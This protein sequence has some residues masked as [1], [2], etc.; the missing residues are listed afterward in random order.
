MTKTTFIILITLFSFSALAKDGRFQLLGISKGDDHKRL[1][2]T[3]TGK[4]WKASCVAV[5]KSTGACSAY[6]WEPEPVRGVSPHAEVQKYIE[7][8]Q[9]LVEAI[10]KNYPK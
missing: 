6:T 10:H 3:Q 9:A 1:V 5:I 4:I 8:E 2:D 7:E